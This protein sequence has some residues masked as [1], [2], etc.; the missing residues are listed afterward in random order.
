MGTARPLRAW[1]ES[2]LAIASRQ[3]LVD[4]IRCP[5]VQSHMGP[6]QVVPEGHAGKFTGEGL[7]SQ[8]N[9][10]QPS[11]VLLHRQNE[12]LD[13]SNAT[14]ASHGPKRG[15]IPFF[16]HQFRNPWQSNCDPRSVIKCVG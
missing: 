10:R 12:L 13:H 2:W 9:Q 16:R 15:L 3:P 7:L 1:F 6:G 14:V 8:R 11:E 5:A 4:L